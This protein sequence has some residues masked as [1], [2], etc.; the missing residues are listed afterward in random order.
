[1]ALSARSP[2]NALATEL[3]YS[4][5]VETA[6]EGIW[7]IDADGI[8]SFANARLAEM[9]AVTVDDMLGASVLE[10]LDEEGQQLAA[11]GLERRRRG[12]EEQLDVRFVRA[13]GSELWTLLSAA[14]ILDDVGEYIGS[15]A[16]VTDI[17]E[18]RRAETELRTSE[19][20]LAEAQ[21]LALLG[22]WS[23]EIATGVV[24]CSTELYRV[25]GV[26]PEV[27][28]A[29]F[30][31][32][33]LLVQ[34][35][36]LVRAE[37]FLQQVQED[38]AGCSDELRITTPRGEERWLALRATPVS[39]DAGHIVEMR[40][41]LQDITERKVSEERLIYMALHDTLTGLAN[42]SLFNDRLDHALARRDVAVAV[43][44]VDVDGFK[45]INDGM[46]HSAGDELLVALAG[47]LSGA[48]RPSDTVARFGGDEFTILL[49]DVDENDAVA[50]AMRLLAELSSP[51]EFGG[52]EISVQAS[53]GLTVGAGDSC[54]A[55]QLLRNADA[56]MYSAKRRGGG[57]HAVFNADLHAE[58]TQRRALEGDLRRVALGSE[59]TLWYQPLVD[60]RDGRLCGFE[61]LLRWNHPERGMISP[62]DFIPIAEETGA[63]IPIGRWVI[64]EACRQMRR[65][66]SEYPSAA[67]LSMNVNLSARQL[68]SPDIADDVAVALEQSGINPAQL[69]LEITETMIMA[70]EDEVGACLQR[71][72]ALGVRISVDD[73]GTGYSSLQHLDRFPIDELK[74]DRSFVSHLGEGDADSGVAL[75]VIRL[76]QSLRIDVVAEGIEREDQL[77]QL[78]GAACTRGQGFYFWKP[79]DAASAETLLRESTSLPMPS[80]PRRSVLVVDDDQSVRRSTCR[81]LADAGYSVVEAKTGHEALRCAAGTLFDAAVVDVHLPDRDGVDLGKELKARS[82][83]ELAVVQLSG[84]AIT[85][86]DRVRALDA[87]ADAYL[88]KPTAPAELIATLGSVLR[89]RRML[90]N[91]GSP[92]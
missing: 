83:G 78:R 11:E 56:A 82:R 53:V 86:D 46:G 43:M 16:M 48:L 65:W 71:L 69:T 8:T 52:R 42:R 72:K 15:L 47:R 79:L 29:S 7:V 4:T 73:F 22:N 55:Q 92:T 61:A 62:C 39:D 36:D 75:A 38:Y 25:I 31:R 27:G 28:I 5:I 1:M 6:T 49:E 40:G 66:H 67:E 63:I 60:L 10:F 87:G 2:A 34:P 44:L 17:T 33:L 68:A 24:T 45:A 84:A 12:E 90:A 3:L 91:A 23:Y 58:V 26:D 76:A 21:A 9:L 18:R 88:L 81:V 14:P 80:A 59:M 19:A 54:D 30:E 13:D 89:K 35:R 32:F 37:V 50:A 64:Q 77:V 57:R 70:D 85:V 41:T 74:I 51:F 20:R